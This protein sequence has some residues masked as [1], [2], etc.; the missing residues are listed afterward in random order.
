MKKIISLILTAVLCALP[1]YITSADSGYTVMREPVY[2]MADSFYSN[3]TKVSKDT[4]WGICDTNGYL[5][6]GYRWE[7]MGEI[8]DSLIPAKKDGMWGYISLEGD[9][10]IPYKFQKAENFI[11]DVAR[12]VTDEGKY[13]YIDRTGEIILTSPFDYSFAMRE[14]LICGVVGGKYGYCDINKNMV[15]APKFDM[16]FDF[17]DGIAAVKSGDAWGYIKSDG[18]Y[19][20]APVYI[21]ASDFSG[22][23]AVCALP[24]GYGIINSSGKRTS[25]FNFDYIGEC[26]EKGRFPAKRGEKSGYINYAG[27]WILELEYDYCYSFTEGVARVFKDEK[28]GYIDEKGNTIVEPVFADCGEYRNER[29]FYSLDGI[30]YGFL[31]LDTQKYQNQT[32]TPTNPAKDEKNE[33]PSVGTYEQIIAVSDIGTTP[34]IPQ[35]DKTISMK[36]GS[37]Y[38]L[39]LSNAK[40]MVASP[41]LIDGVTMVPLRDTVEYMGGKISWEAETKRIKIDFKANKIIMTVGSKISF[42]NGLAMPIAAAPVLIDGVTMIPVRSVATNLKCDVEWVAETQNIYIY[43]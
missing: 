3:V 43:Y 30:T 8:V 16:G 19:L 21:H 13:A 20:A 14:G 5:L 10:K 15:I 1:I 24:T 36:I 41:A 42:V 9:E 18:T 7:A 28:W 12:V 32:V 6:S 31:T 34:A 33:A 11:E 35:N 23:Y 4:L 38:A 37:V 22:G 29:A 26:D 39:K 2:N 17:H 27:D 25:E 40:K